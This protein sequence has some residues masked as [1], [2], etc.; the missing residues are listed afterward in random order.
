MTSGSTHRKVKSL[1]EL[2]RISRDLRASG[3]TIVQCHGVFDLLHPGHIKHFEAAKKEGDILI[4]TVTEDRY[5]GKGPGRPVFNERLRAE[6]IAGLECVDYVAINRHPTAVPAIATLK[7]HVY[8]KG[9]DYAD[10]EKDMT[11]EIGNEENAVKSAGGRIHFTDEISFSSTELINVHFSVYHPEA[12]EFLR[13]FRKR[14]STDEII[15]KLK[16]LKKMKVLIIGD[17]IVDEYHYC[18][19][20]G[21]AWKETVIATRYLNKESFA[22]GVLAAANHIAG[23]CE[24]VHLV[25]C[26]GSENT[27]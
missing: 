22:G 4:V 24:D 26:L 1:E 7:P 21:K 11:G 6:S 25:T 23:F 14:Y 15:G 27:Q 10:R 17:S 8:A 5:V 16:G 12:D 13:G 20:M 19:P 18:Q 2:E 3:K 9:S